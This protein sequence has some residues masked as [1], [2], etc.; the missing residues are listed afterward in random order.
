MSRRLTKPVTVRFS[1]ERILVSAFG[2]S[3]QK[4]TAVISNPILAVNA[5]SRGECIKHTALGPRPCGVHIDRK[6]LNQHWRVKEC[7]INLNS[8]SNQGIGNPLDVFIREKVRDEVDE[9]NK[10]HFQMVCCQDSVR[11]T[12]EGLFASD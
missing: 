6:R 11:V 2:P 10:L 4:V 8:T 3:E 9:I 7:F 1:L 5:D 12:E